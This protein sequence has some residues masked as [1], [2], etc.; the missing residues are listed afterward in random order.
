MAD[1]NFEQNVR[2]RMEGFTISPS[3]TVWQQV[4][5]ELQKKKR[6]RRWFFI[7]LPMIALLGG[8]AMYAVNQYTGKTNADAATI[9]KQQT[10]PLTVVTNEPAQQIIDEQPVK[11]PAQ[12]KKKTQQQAIVQTTQINTAKPVQQSSKNKQQTTQTVK[13][14][15][16]KTNDAKPVLAVNSV[17][18]VNVQSQIPTVTTKLSKKSTV[19]D[20]P[21]GITSGQYKNDVAASVPSKNNQDDIPA[22]TM[23][24]KEINSTIAVTADSTKQVTITNTEQVS[25]PDTTTAVANPEKP[26]VSV[27]VIQTPKYKWQMG[28]QVNAGI[29]NIGNISFPFGAYKSAE[30]DVNVNSGGAITG[31]PQSRITNSYNYNIKSGLQFGG[32]LLLRKQV[33]KKIFIVTGL[34]YQ[35]SSYTADE[36][37]KTDSVFLP[38]NA[39][40]TIS[41]KQ[42][43]TNFKT[44]YIN[45]P[46]ELQW[47]ILKRKSGSF[48]LSAGVQHFIR[49]SKKSIDSI[50]GFISPQSISLATTPRVKQPTVALYQPMLHFAPSYEWQ[51]KNNMFSLGWYVNYGFLKVYSSNS[52]YHWRQTGL[53]FRYFFPAK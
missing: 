30:A 50:P 22:N 21:V 38:T 12:V 23:T 42:N 35:Y 8:G 33:A 41:N 39:N 25:K 27:P 49:V 46:T 53:T 47:Q 7:W 16:A 13:Q 51:K 14:V 1:K 48:N 40:Y 44:H 43:I 32:G 5:A 4:N 10:V 20:K 29:A 17:K 31:I 11:L 34:Q 2:G 6:K 19:S 52:K 26:A 36:Q 18:K 45:I 28:W 24:A 15:T 37:L 9:A 3:A